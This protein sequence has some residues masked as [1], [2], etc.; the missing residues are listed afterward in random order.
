MDNLRHGI[1]LQL[2]ASVSPGFH[3]R[4]AED[5]HRCAQPKTS[6]VCCLRKGKVAPV[7]DGWDYLYARYRAATSWLSKLCL[8]GFDFWKFLRLWGYTR[9]LSISRARSPVHWLDMHKL[10]TF[11]IS[12]CH[13][14]GARSVSRTRAYFSLF[15]GSVICQTLVKATAATLPSRRPLSLS[16]LSTCLGGSEC[17]M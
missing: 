5:N 17:I 16:L 14:I 6:R 9:H 10:R 15:W 3:S 8:P 13:S 4:P 2:Y 1:Q 11:A 12:Q 7:G